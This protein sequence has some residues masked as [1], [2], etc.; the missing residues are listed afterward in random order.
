M[1]WSRTFLLWIVQQLGLGMSH[2]GLL[3]PFLQHPPGSWTS[4]LYTD[5][6]CATAYVASSSTYY[7]LSP[8][9]P[10]IGRLMDG[11]LGIGWAAT[12][13]PYAEQ[14]DLHWRPSRHRATRTTNRVYF[15]VIL[16]W[17]SQFPTLYRSHTAIAQFTPCM[18]S[19]KVPCC[20]RVCVCETSE[21]M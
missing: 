15:F 20:G 9:G 3:A 1:P 5:W 4:S 8:V 16:T 14:Y 10:S 18:S 13:V 2:S 12:R 21:Q 19:E 11:C 7:G 17:V 6:H